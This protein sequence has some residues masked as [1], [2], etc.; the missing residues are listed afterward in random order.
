MINVILHL[1]LFLTVHWS[2]G[3]DSL[4]VNIYHEVYIGQPGLEGAQNVWLEE[5]RRRYF[6]AV[7]LK[8]HSSLVFLLVWCLVKDDIYFVLTEIMR[9]SGMV[10]NQG[11][12]D[13]DR[14]QHGS[15]S[16]IVSSNLIPNVGGTSLG[17]WSGLQHEVNMYS[18]FHLHNYLYYFEWLNL[19]FP[20]SNHIMKF[21]L[22]IILSLDYISVML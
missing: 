20:L 21:M 8:V 12:G 9:V 5:G 15:P 22:E 13:F 17:G 19:C 7:T 6:F 1:A 10:S 2:C 3:N 4:I 14:M 18:P 16:P 11:F